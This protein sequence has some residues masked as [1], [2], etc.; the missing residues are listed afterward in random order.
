MDSQLVLVLTR[1]IEHKRANGRIQI[2]G[3]STIRD[4]VTAK[5]EGVN[6]YNTNAYRC[7]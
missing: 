4:D 5:K 6:C 2:E 1:Y 3:T 7:T